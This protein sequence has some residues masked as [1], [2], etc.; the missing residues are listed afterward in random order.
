MRGLNYKTPEQDFF[1]LKVTWH[2]YF[3]EKIRTF[4]H[5]FLEK[6]FRQTDRW[7]VFQIT[8]Y[9]WVQQNFLR[10]GVC[11]LYSRGLHPVFTGF[12]LYIHGVCTLYSWGLHSIFS[13]HNFLWKL[14]TI[15]CIFEKPQCL[16]ICPNDINLNIKE[17]EFAQKIRLSHFQKI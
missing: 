1:S 5:E 6:N 3:M 11:T 14:Q 17:D 9:S 2:L 4:L 15:F 13:S 16:N 12:S 8:L 7:R 10:H